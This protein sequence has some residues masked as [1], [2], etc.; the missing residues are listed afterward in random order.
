MCNI[1]PVEKC[2]RYKHE[3]HIIIMFLFMTVVYSTGIQGHL[4]NLMLILDDAVDYQSMSSI[5]SIFVI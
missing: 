1:S 3:K 5:N 4:K 2:L